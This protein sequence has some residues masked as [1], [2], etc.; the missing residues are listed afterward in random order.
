MIIFLKLNFNLYAQ[1]SNK[2]FRISTKPK[3]GLLAANKKKLFQ[4]SLM[5]LKCEEERNEFYL[6]STENSKRKSFM[7]VMIVK[8]I[9]TLLFLD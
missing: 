1:I 7:C 8:A 3:R 9:N 5:A 4:F 6:K 2:T